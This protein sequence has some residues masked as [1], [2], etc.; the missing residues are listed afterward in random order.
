[1]RMPYLALVEAFCLGKNEGSEIMQ[2]AHRRSVFDSDRARERGG[3][4]GM[5]NGCHGD[6]QTAS[7]V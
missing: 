1:M 7:S 5:D 2:R 6:L 3:P 4:V